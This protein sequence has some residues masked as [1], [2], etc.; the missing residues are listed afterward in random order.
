MIRYFL[1]FCTLLSLALPCLAQ[2]SGDYIFTRRNGSDNAP[3]VVSPGTNNLLKVNGSGVISVVAD[4]TYL[5]ENQTISLSGD[6][7]GNGATAITTTLANTAVTPGSYT[8][9]NIT[10][11]AKGRITAAA[12]GSGGGGGSLPSMTGNANKLLT[13]NGSAASWT[14]ALT[15]L[16]TVAQ[17]DLHTL[18][19]TSNSQTPVNRILLENLQTAVADTES[20]LADSY[21]RSPSIV[22]KANN[23]TGSTSVARSADIWGEAFDVMYIVAGTGPSDR[24]FT[25]GN[26]YAHFFPGSIESTQ[27]LSIGNTASEYSLS[28][29]VNAAADRGEICG[30]AIYIALGSQ[31]LTF[32][33]AGTGTSTFDNGLTTGSGDDITGQ[34]SITTNSASEGIGYRTGSGGTV[35]QA[36]S[37][38]TGVTLNT[39]TGLITCNSTSLAAGAEAAFVV[40]NSSVA[41]TDTV[42]VNVV[43]SSTGTPVA[44]VTAVSAGSFTVTLSNLHASTA[45]TTADT[46]RF[47][48]IK[49]VSN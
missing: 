40:T 19:S 31:N 20:G 18:T 26:R 8:S 21:Q 23:W 35:T 33:N 42:I 2:S 11:D 1:H 10:V 38:T 7:T 13:N 29:A 9:A 41:A 4:T 36:T 37:R 25:L 3:V 32:N 24:W 14:A 5:T 45:D 22:L 15:G 39:M 43:S 47:T 30:Q 27:F 46:I 34:G 28:L 49:S 48:V 44:F 17:T 12:N 16:T 6:V